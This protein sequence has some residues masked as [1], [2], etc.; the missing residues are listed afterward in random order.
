MEPAT[1]TALAVGAGILTAGYFFKQEQAYREANCV[2]L[3]PWTT[4]VAGMGAGAGLVWLGMRHK[5]FMIS[6]MG[7]GLATL[8]LAQFVRNKELECPNPRQLAQ[9]HIPVRDTASEAYTEQARDMG[10]L[11]DGVAWTG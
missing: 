7:A 4:E 1:K 10:L 11:E 8:Q 9:G 5:S 2:Y 6:M 3:S